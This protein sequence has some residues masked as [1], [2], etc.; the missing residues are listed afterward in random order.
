MKKPYEIIQIK[1]K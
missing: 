1:L